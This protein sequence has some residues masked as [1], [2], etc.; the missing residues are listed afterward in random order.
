MYKVTHLKISCHKMLRKKESWKN[1]PTDQQHTTFPVDQNTFVHVLD[2]YCEVIA[3][4][5]KG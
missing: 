5:Y 4:P 3:R 1:L 2:F